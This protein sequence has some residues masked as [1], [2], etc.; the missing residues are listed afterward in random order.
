M[1]PLIV[2]GAATLRAR[3]AG[4][5]DVTALDWPLFNPSYTRNQYVVNA[6]EIV[7]RQ[8]A[9]PR[10]RASRRSLLL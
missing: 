10:A 2:S 3:L 8:S 5:L 4:R 6:D 9:R 1:A 7:S